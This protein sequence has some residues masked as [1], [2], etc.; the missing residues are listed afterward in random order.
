MAPLVPKHTTSQM[1]QGVQRWPKVSIFRNSVYVIEILPHWSICYFRRPWHDF[2]NG[3]NLGAELS[4][5][6]RILI[7]RLDDQSRRG[8]SYW[9][10]PLSMTSKC[11]RWGHIS[12]INGEKISCLLVFRLILLTALISQSKSL[13]VYVIMKERSTKSLF[14]K[15]DLNS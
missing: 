11:I 15:K 7:D 13:K 6:N 1:T 3:L 4:E 12:Y 2:M 8:F 14:L 9:S 10:H 5:W